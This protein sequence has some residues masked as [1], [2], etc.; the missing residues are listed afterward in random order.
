MGFLFELKD[1]LNALGFR[2][3]II[4][5]SVL[6]YALLAEKTKH[7]FESIICDLFVYTYIFYRNKCPSFE[8]KSL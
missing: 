8:I 7:Y 2:N 4:A 3:K 6:V 5:V 1:K